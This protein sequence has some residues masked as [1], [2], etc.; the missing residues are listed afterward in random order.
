MTLRT[1]NK[2]RGIGD[3]GDEESWIWDGKTFRLAEVK[4]MP[5][6]RGVPGDDWPVIY[7]AERK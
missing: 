2:G 1:F 4:T 6:C 5:H 3:C 7:R